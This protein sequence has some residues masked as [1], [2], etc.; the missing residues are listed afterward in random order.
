MKGSG[1]ELAIFIPSMRGDG[2]ERVTLT[3]AVSLLRSGVPVDLVLAS[4]EGALLDE[5]PPDLPVVDLKRRR[6]LASL[7]RLVAYL[8]RA[9]P[10]ILLACLAHA[11]IVAV[12]ARRL[13]GVR[14]RL[15]LTEHNTMSREAANTSLRRGRLVP[16]LAR[17]TYPD[18]DA[19]VAVSKGVAAD[20]TSSIGLA[21]DRIQVIYNPVV[22][23][24]FLSRAAE[25]IEDLWFVPGAD[26]VVLSVG[27]LVPQKSYPTLIEAFAAI[28]ARRR[29]K[30]LI[31]GEGPCR[32]EL[33]AAIAGL[34]LESEIRLPGFVSNPASYMRRSSVFAMSS[35]FEGLPTVMIEALATGAR[36][37]STD[38]PSGPR[39]ILEGGRYGR[40]VPVGDASRLAAAL[41]EAL[42][43][44][45][46]RPGPESWQRFELETVIDQYRQLFWQADS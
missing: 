29:A 32:D 26:P 35:V 34:G 28:R 15:V 3:L 2:A 42:D 40:L 30:L 13:S 43:D 14:S 7:P 20:L 22:T 36:I 16:P 10:T 9:R 41:E 38:C 21:E 45:T 44:E 24:E 33:H 19:I 5:I 4:A 8:R 11:N 27:R 46:P 18:A 1:T 25:P 37:V 31:L 17:R 12:W 23:P 6:T 39:E